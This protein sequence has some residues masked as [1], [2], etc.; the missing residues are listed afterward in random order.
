MDPST[1]VAASPVGDG[2]DASM[3]VRACSGPTP[4]MSTPGSCLHERRQNQ[5]FDRACAEAWSCLP[6]LLRL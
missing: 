1:G 5:V 2:M 4:T 3:L 6:M